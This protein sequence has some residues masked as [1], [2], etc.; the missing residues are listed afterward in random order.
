MPDK[1]KPPHALVVRWGKYEMEAIGIPAIAVIA[2]LLVLGAR[3]L[4]LI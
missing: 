4:G 1:S 3:W 2:V